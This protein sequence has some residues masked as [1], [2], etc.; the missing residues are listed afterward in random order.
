MTEPITDLTKGIYRRM[1]AGFIKGHRI[2]NLSLEAEA[3][4]W[5]IN[6][7]ADDFGN[8][9]AEPGLCFAATV[10]RRKEITVEMV[11]S[12]L[13]E[14]RESGLIQMYADESGDKYLHI[15][16]FEE[17]QPSGKNG[18]KV[19][20]FPAWES[21]GIQGKPD[22]DLASHSHTD[23]H[24][25]D[26]PDQQQRATRS[27]GKQGTRMPEDFQPNEAVQEWAAKEAGRVDLRI[28]LDE[29]RD[30][31]RAIPG[32]RGRKLDWDATF[33]NRLRE[34]ESRAGRN[35]SG[36]K[37]NTEA[38]LDAVRGVIAEYERD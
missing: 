1:Y 16:D 13:D 2:N 29:F 3:W 34:L 18:R 33:R 28:A 38:S 27:A 37:S 15:V 19:R 9:D 20:K 11:S 14:M 8:A 24:T 12:W 6:A 22:V 10:G 26:D 30:Y 7:S 17:L 36:R 35:G 31:W 32:A 5:R 25:Q 4:F 21:R 23:T